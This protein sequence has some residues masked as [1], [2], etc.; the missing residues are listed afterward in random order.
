MCFVFGLAATAPPVLA[1]SRCDVHDRIAARLD[2]TFGEVPIGRGLQS[3]QRMFEIW[4]S[5][6]TGSWTILLVRP[7][8]MACIMAAGTAW[9]EARRATPKPDP[10]R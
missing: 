3:P 8:G 5:A 1:Q 10:D 7:D 6:R 2:Q 4:H 9:V